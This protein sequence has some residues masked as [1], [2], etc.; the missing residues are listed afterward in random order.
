MGG[1]LWAHCLTF[2]AGD[3]ERECQGITIAV[4]VGWA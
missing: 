2:A 3:S 4:T 1:K